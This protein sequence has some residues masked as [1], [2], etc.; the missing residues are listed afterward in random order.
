MNLECGGESVSFRGFR[1]SPPT[2]DRW[3]ALQA[4]RFGLMGKAE[5]LFFDSLIERN[6]HVADVGAN[7][8]L[9][10]LYFSRQS[11]EGRVYAFEPDPR[12]FSALK[13]NVQRNR[14]RECASYSTLQ[15]PV[16]P[17]D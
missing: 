9:Y 1:F 10:T 6:W 12:L 4:H 15:W 16:K 7:Q 17:Q 2:L 3:V 5:F 13:E 11:P 14:R 8:G